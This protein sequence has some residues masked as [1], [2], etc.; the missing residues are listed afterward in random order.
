MYI[1]GTQLPPDSPCFTGMDDACKA[2]LA[3]TKEDKAK[4]QA[5]AEQIKRTFPAGAYSNSPPEDVAQLMA[6]KKH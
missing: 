2:S 4:T 3:A 1:V 5:M 6:K